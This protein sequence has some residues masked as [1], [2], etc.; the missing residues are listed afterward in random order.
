MPPQH[1]IDGDVAPCRPFFLALTIV[2]V[3]AVAQR[4]GLSNRTLVLTLTAWAVTFSDVAVRQYNEG[5]GTI[6]RLAWAT[7]ARRSRSVQS[8]C[9]VGGEGLVRHPQCRQ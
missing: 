2:A 6:T 1:S 3:A 5:V 7:A 9:A 4:Y 8:R